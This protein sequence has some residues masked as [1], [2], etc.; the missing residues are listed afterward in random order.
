MKIFHRNIHT[1][2]GRY[3]DETKIRSRWHDRPESTGIVCGLN[4]WPSHGSYS[5]GM[6]FV[7]CS[8]LKLYHHSLGI[9]PAQG[10]YSSGMYG[11]FLGYNHNTTYT[12]SYFSVMYGFVLGYNY[13]ITYTSYLGLSR[14]IL[15]MSEGGIQER[16]INTDPNSFWYWKTCRHFLVFGHFHT[17]VG[18][19][20][21]H[22]MI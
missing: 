2:F 10:S 11:V 21:S 13:T 6:Y 3:Q 20:H 4:H 7:W 16:D 19:I 17:I 18:N 14:Y 15:H 1:L 12:S 9:L 22:H 5:W 8:W